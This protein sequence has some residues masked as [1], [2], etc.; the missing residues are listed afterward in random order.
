MSNARRRPQSG[1]A[2]TPRDH[3]QEVTDRIIAALEQGVVPWR[4]PRDPAKAG[5]DT[6]PRN[7]ATRHVYR[8]INVVLLAMSP[9][10]FMTG[11]NRWCSY[12]QASERGWQVRKCERGTTVFFFRQLAV[13]ERY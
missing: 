3:Y 4:R 6:M 10:S 11:D 12:R 2:H 9:L 7:A 13:K 8:G 5:Q 1:Q